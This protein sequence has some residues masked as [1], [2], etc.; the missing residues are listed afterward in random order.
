MRF[1]D[2]VRCTTTTVGTGALAFGGAA[3]S[4]FRT[5]IEAGALTG[6]VVSYMIEQD[7]DFE[8]GT[9]TIADGG[10]TLVRSTV[11][12]SKASG[13]L[14]TGLIELNGVSAIVSL[15]VSAA[16]L[17]TLWD[18]TRYWHREKEVVITASSYAVQLSDTGRV[19]AINAS[20]AATLSL[21]PLAGTDEHVFLVSNIS[22][23]LVTV[24]PD[25]SET[26][27]NASTLVLR[28]GTLALIRP[29]SDKSKWR[30]EGWTSLDISGGSAAYPAMRVG[31]E[32]NGFWQAGSS[33]Y[34][35]VNG[36]TVM[37]LGQNTAAFNPPAGGSFTQFL[38]ADLLAYQ[39]MISYNSANTVGPTIFLQRGRG[40]AASP[41]D[42]A[43]NDQIG[44]LRFQA[45]AG[46]AYREAG[47]I[48]YTMIETTPGSGALAARMTGT[49]ARLGTTTLVEVYKWE[50]DTG[51][52]V[53]G[54]N[55]V[56]GKGHLKRRQYAAGSL[57][58]ASTSTGTDF[59]SSDA[60]S[61]HLTS[62]GTNIVAPGVKVLNALAANGTISIPGGFRVMGIAYANTT[63]N[64]V[65]G[66]IKIGT[67]SGGTDVVAAQAVGANAIGTVADA[68][69]LKRLFSR[70]AAQT[71]YIQAVTAWNSASV[72]LSLD[73]KKVF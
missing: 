53:L 59:A 22:T 7:A 3:S 38:T 4:A 34:A 29:A 45:Y 63:A 12:L 27:G 11:L 49:M 50:A 6:D 47:Q 15:I 35:A 56:D 71:L 16:E 43:T 66:G 28:P 73:L 24:D 69:I 40:S 62:D 33:L 31:A 72:E 60:N 1:F 21:P 17:Q 30:A 70:T 25:G 23:S 58:A 52:W 64:A 19:L 8:V 26:I 46:G 9:G 67:T 57:P 20:G 13:V 10:A 44:V 2:R 54:I 41:A 39:R 32:G 61:A 68:D 18:Q 55:V 5:P 65:T 42:I 48:T 36:A 14:G 51:L 37:G